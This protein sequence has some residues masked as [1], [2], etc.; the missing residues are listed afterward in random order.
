MYCTYVCTVCTTFPTLLNQHSHDV[1]RTTDHHR[2]SRRYSILSNAHFQISTKMY[3]AQFFKIRKFESTDLPTTK[4]QKSTW[5]SI[6]FQSITSTKVVQETNLFM[7]LVLYR[8]CVYNLA[9]L[10]VRGVPCTVG[11]FLR[12]N[13]LARDCSIFA[14]PLTS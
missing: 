8:P 10:C 7:P 5:T 13:N 3:V 2:R 11:W 4:I 6:N 12:L 1:Y 14:Q 9:T